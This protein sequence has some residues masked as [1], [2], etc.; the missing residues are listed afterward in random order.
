MNTRGLMGLIAISVGKDLGLL[1]D[2]L[3]TMFVIMCFLTT[4]VTAPMLRLW[5]PDHLKQLL[6]GKG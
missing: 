2:P 4:A 1:S 6:P 3:Y 5:L